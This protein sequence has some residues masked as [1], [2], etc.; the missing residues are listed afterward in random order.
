MNR[1]IDT[2]KGLNSQLDDLPCRV[3][4][5]DDDVDL[6][7]CYEAILSGSD[8][9]VEAMSEP[10]KGLSAIDTFKPDVIV[11][12]MYM[13]DCSGAELVQMIRQDDRYALIPVIFLS[14]EQ[15]VNNQLHAMSLGADDFLTKPVHA[16][17]LVAIINTAAKRARNNV[18]LNRN[19]KSSLQENKYQLV[20]LDEHAIVSAADVAGRII[21]VNDKLCEISGYSRDELLDQNHNILK[22]GY[23]DKNFYK[24]LW[25]T[26]SRGEIWHG[27][28]CNKTKNE[29]EYWVDSTIVPFLRSEERRVGK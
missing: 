13:P 12:D 2:I 5:I 18:N 7:E 19:L 11:V 27:V 4:I 10:L 26:I 17:K 16:S 24:N 14:A 28:I 6:L 23:H 21:H 25:D 8:L 15:D 22:S 1:V 9:I 29:D 3:M 20:T